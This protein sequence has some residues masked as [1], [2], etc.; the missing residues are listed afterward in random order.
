MVIEKVTGPWE[1]FFF[2]LRIRDLGKAT[3]GSSM[4]FCFE[5]YF[6]ILIFNAG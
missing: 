4:Q 3:S 6:H 2:W 1:N 5:E